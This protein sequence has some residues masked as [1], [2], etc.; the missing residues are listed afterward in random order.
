MP[1]CRAPAARTL[2]SFRGRDSLTRATAQ[3]L[4]SG[5]RYRLEQGEDGRGR[6]DALLVGPGE[7]AHCGQDVVL[8]EVSP[9]AAN[10][11]YDLRGDRVNGLIRERRAGR[12]DPVPRRRELGA[13]HRP[14][15]LPCVDEPHSTERQ[16]GKPGGWG[17]MSDGGMRDRNGH[18]ATSSRQRR[19]NDATYG[20]G[21]GELTA[22]RRDRPTAAR[23]KSRPGWRG[24]GSTRAPGRRGA[25][26]ARPATASKAS[27]HQARATG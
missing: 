25:F 8:T 2:A 10:G 3:L 12:V 24:E 17:P 16:G 18:I 26:D 27:L 7:L 11:G 20:S 15:G 4:P 21:P 6:D 23:S 1:P 19:T 22:G 9:P 14:P 13:V 5:C